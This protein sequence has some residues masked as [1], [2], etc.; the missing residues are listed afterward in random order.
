MET[1]HLFQLMKRFFCAAS[2]GLTISPVFVAPIT[3]LALESVLLTT[4]GV[5]SVMNN[6]PCAEEMGRNVNR[7]R[8]SPTVWDCQRARG[9]VRGIEMRIIRP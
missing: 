3:V 1:G 8:F 6:Q 4:Q 5:E 9:P 7:T 2:L